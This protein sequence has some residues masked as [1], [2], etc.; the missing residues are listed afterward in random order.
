M[1]SNVTIINHLKK[2]NA[3]T[4]PAKSFW[5]RYGGSNMW[6]P[7]AYVH[8]FSRWADPILGLYQLRSPICTDSTYSIV[9]CSSL[10]HLKDILTIPFQ[11][12]V[13]TTNSKS[14]WIF[15]PNS[16]LVKSSH[17]GQ[18]KQSLVGGIPTPLKNDGVRQLGRLFPN[19]WGEKCSKPPTSSVCG[20]VNYHS[21]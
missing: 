6:R 2:R 14:H 21:W 4:D 10:P 11:G 12:Y 8:K 1:P 16:I 15:N 7:S 5:I 9:G 3:A 17:C 18:Q 20:H 13:W 19:I